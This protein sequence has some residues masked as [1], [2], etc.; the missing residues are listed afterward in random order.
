MILSEIKTMD[1]KNRLH[2]NHNYLKLLGIENNSSVV[3]TVDGESERIIIRK[4]SEY[5]LAKLKGGKNK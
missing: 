5:E 1:Q 3:V 2:I 4:L